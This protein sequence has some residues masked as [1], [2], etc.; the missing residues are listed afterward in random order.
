MLTPEALSHVPEITDMTIPTYVALGGI[1]LDGGEW[2]KSSHSGLQDCVTARAEILN[3]EVSV[4]QARDSKAPDT[5]PVLN[6]SPQA[7]AS[8][9]D[10]L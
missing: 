3:G 4:I 6:F 5:A 2:G 1:V 8:F 10:N 7:W 9:K